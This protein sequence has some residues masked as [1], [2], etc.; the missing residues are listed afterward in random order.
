MSETKQKTITV[1]L[2]LQEAITL[3]GYLDVRPSGESAESLR[4]VR[5][6][7]ARTFMTVVDTNIESEYAAQVGYQSAKRRKGYKS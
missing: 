2:T 5:D 6:R 7:I 1:E 3:W 4:W